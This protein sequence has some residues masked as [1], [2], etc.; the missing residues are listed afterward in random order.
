MTTIH[1][2]EFKKRRL[3][4]I[5]FMLAPEMKIAV[6]YYC[7]FREVRKPTPVKLYSVDNRKLKTVT[8]WVCQ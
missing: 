2:K 7:M 6:N 1:K 5:D 4:T 3:G 8:S